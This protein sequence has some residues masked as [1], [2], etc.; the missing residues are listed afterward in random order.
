M[1]LG[2]IPLSFIQHIIHNGAGAFLENTLYFTGQ[3][4][5]VIIYLFW[6][7]LI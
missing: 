7:G 6:S 3:V 1:N 2:K 5:L 4:D